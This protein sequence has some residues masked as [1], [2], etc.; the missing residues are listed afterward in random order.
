MP[1]ALQ[2]RKRGCF[3]ISKIR[4]GARKHVW[5]SWHPGNIGEYR[6]I[7]ELWAVWHEDTIIDGIGQMPPL[8]LV[9]EE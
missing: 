3:T 8:Q 7:K 6:S 1:G 2:Q 4:W 9:E 5:A